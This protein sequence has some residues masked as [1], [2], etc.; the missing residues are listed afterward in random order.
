MS[1]GWPPQTVMLASREGG[2]YWRR[3]EPEVWG[4][5]G[6]FFDGPHVF[7]VELSYPTLSC[8]FCCWASLA[9][10]RLQ[11]NRAS[12][13]PEWFDAAMRWS[14][15]LTSSPILCVLTPALQP[16]STVFLELGLS[17]YFTKPI[18]LV[19]LFEKYPLGFAQSA[20]A[21]FETCR[22]KR[23]SGSEWM[24]KEH[25]VCPPCPF[26]LRPPTP[27]FMLWYWSP[28]PELVWSLW[29]ATGNGTHTVSLVLLCVELPWVLSWLPVG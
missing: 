9:W 10:T 29:G 13:E 5:A 21:H 25:L 27:F 24:Q 17:G 2:L 4:K 19:N 16:S 3:K 28:A 22:R 20:F 18:Q 26:P 1:I 6:N 8:C 7:N 23:Q 12:E 15:S 11:S 14:G